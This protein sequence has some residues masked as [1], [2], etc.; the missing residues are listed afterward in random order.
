M[1]FGALSAF[2]LLTAVKVFT[3]KSFDANYDTQ[4]EISQR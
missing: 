3:F 2:E 1:D 4:G